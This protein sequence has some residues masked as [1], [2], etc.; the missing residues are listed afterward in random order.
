[1]AD[2]DTRPGPR[3]HLHALRKYV[4]KPV[5]GALERAER[6]CREIDDEREAFEAL[7]ERVADLRTASTPA[8]PVPSVSAPVPRSGAD[9][10]D[11]RE[12]YRET[13]MAVPHYEAVY[14][15]PL[16]TNA[17]AEFGPDIGSLFASETTSRLLPAQ[18]QTIVSA[19]RQAAA[20]RAEVCETLEDEITSLRSLRGE[21]TAVLD[22]LDSTVVPSWY[23][24]QFQESL[25]SIITTRQ[26]QLD[27]RT[28]SHLDGH[29]LCESLYED[30]PQ[31]YPVLMAVARLVDCVAVKE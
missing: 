28:L 19:A 30:Q 3:E 20:D 6:E 12:A 13:V 1:M 27:E 14:D 8:R 17:R 31:T 18:Q 2:L 21:I 5:S 25:L 29:N 9:G 22:E 11:L 23:Y 26:S 16:V 24:P 15:E 4:R 7:A 10:E